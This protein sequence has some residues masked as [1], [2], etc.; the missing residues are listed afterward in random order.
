MGDSTRLVG[1]ENEIGNG[2]VKDGRSDTRN[3]RLGGGRKRDGRW[4]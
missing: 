1:S 4:R 3:G 2:T